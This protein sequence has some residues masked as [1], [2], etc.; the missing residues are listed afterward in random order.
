MLFDSRP[1]IDDLLLL[2]SELPERDVSPYAHLAADIGHERPHEGVPG[3]DRPSV[4]GERLVRHQR[5]LV[6][7][8][9]DAGAPAAPA[10][11]AAVEGEILSGRRIEPR[12]ALRADRLDA[13]SAGK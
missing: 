7:L 4:D 9:H 3:S 8:P 5:R 1:V 11:P 12:A 10:G 13:L 2:C 6:N